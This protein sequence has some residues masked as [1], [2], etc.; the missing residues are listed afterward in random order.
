MKV[1][2]EI[3]LELSR[4]GQQI[5]LATHDYVLL[6]WF[7]LLQNKKRDDSIRYHTLIRSESGGFEIQS[8]NDYNLLDKSAISNAY[9]ELYDAEI[10]RALQ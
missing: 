3:L 7:D 5:I 4:D 9:A 2:V 6:K 10:E 1:L 8:R